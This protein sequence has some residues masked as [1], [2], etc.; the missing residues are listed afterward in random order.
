MSLGLKTKATAT[1]TP[2]A[3]QEAGAKFQGASCRGFIRG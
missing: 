3:K 2:Q 1:R